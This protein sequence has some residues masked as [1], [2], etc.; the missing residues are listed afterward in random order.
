M[1]ADV[2]DIVYVSEKFKET[3]KFESEEVLGQNASCAFLFGRDTRKEHIHRIKTA[4]RTRTAL[5][6]SLI[7]YKR[8]GK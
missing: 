5:K 8:T 7:M 4:A 6:T 2:T 3:T 1:T